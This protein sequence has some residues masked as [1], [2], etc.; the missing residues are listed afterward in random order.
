MLT[1]SGTISLN[2]IQAEFGGS[3]PIAIS[4]YYRGGVLVPDTLANNLIPT[5]GTIK[6]TDF[7]GGDGTVSY[8]YILFY[9]STQEDACAGDDSLFIYQS[10][11]PFSFTQPIYTNS[12][13][14]NLAP[15]DWYSDEGIGSREWSGTAWLG[16]SAELCPLEGGGG[17][18]GLEPD[19]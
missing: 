7:Y 17:G 2:N 6:L 14:T 12:G 13:L 1:G 3:N 11:E 19:F 8:L 18:G 16:E 10:V 4:E 9:G 5:S 15:A